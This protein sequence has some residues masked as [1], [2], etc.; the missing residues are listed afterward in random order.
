MAPIIV[1]ALPIRYIGMRDGGSEMRERPAPAEAA[2]SRQPRRPQGD[3][4]AGIAAPAAGPA[5]V[6]RLQQA[7]GNRRTAALLRK[8]ESARPPASRHERG[9]SGPEP[10]LTLAGEGGFGEPQVLWTVP[11]VP[12]GEGPY[13]ARHAQRQAVQREGEGG[14]GG[15]GGGPNLIFAETAKKNAERVRDNTA[16]LVAQV[17]LYDAAANLAFAAYQPKR[18][19]TSR[20]YRDAF[21]K[22]TNVLGQAKLAAERQN[23]IVGVV[24]GAVAS[25]VVGVAA[26]AVLPASVLS[27]A[28]FS[29]ATIT[30]VSAQGVISSA[31]GTAISSAVATDTNF[32][33]AG[34][35]NDEELDAWKTMAQLQEQARKVSTLGAK[36][37]YL[38]GNAEYAI[39]QVNAHVDGGKPEMGWADTL[40]LVTD[41]MDIDKS[42]SRLTEPLKE[43][44]GKMGEL[45]STAENMEVPSVDALE[46]QIWIVWISGLTNSDLLD[47]DAIEDHLHAIGVL[48]KNSILGVDFGRWTT[49]DD[50]KEAIA[51]AKTK[52]S[53]MEEQKKAAQPNVGLQ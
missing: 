7:V 4:S 1:G 20:N 23:L 52:A 36:L 28:A 5:G 53:E 9:D 49:E 48:G 26:A 45:K 43:A 51:A 24:I 50:E 14:G 37:G 16:G 18:M 35:A 2:S 3:A 6:L 27:A 47:R 21:A 31:A 46:R 13:S 41:M 11:L 19:A 42:T 32:D 12:A 25:A 33:A 15:Q 8:Q 22:H 39:A 44:T 10:R 17:A 30:S 38:L 29:A 34:S 40:T